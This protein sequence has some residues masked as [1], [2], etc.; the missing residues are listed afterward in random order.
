MG[1]NPQTTPGNKYY[2]TSREME[3][4]IS[5]LEVDMSNLKK[6]LE[7]EKIR[8]GDFER[9]VASYITRG[10]RSEVD[11][12]HLQERLRMSEQRLQEGKRQSQEAH[13]R[14]VAL[15]KNLKRETDR[16]DMLETKV[17]ELRN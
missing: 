8:S 10:E 5:K 4:Q 9:Q 7:D 3:L 17:A 12:L 1:G 2:L 13:T 11:H 6:E 14:M 15:I 16:A